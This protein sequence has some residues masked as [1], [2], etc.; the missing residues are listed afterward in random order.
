MRAAYPT[1]DPNSA[2]GAIGFVG[3][4]FANQWDIAPGALPNTGGR[5]AG[6]RKTIPAPNWAALAV[7]WN[8]G[9][10]GIDGTHP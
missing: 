6:S 7:A 3:N 4:P 8:A 9:Y 5:T 2:E 1:L 10:L